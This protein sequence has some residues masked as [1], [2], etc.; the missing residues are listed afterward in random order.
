MHQAVKISQLDSNGFGLVASE[1]IP[2]GSE[3]IAL[4]DHIPLQF[5]SVE[6]DGSDAGY[7]ALVN[8][9]RLVPD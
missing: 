4:P 3:L 8:L 9:A 5:G 1:D 6:T 2:K 7:A